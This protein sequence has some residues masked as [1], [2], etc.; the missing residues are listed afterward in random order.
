MGQAGCQIGNGCWELFCLEHGIQPDGQMPSDKV[1]APNKA[2][3]TRIIRPSPRSSCCTVTLPCGD[4]V[5]APTSGRAPP[6]ARR[7]KQM[8][9]RN[10]AP[11]P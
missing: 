7:I 10:C 4:A 2:L 1:R 3:F 5:G 9:N 8:T 11:P 6:P